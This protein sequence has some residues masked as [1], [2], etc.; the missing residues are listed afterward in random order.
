MFLLE[1]SHRLPGMSMD[2]RPIQPISLTPRRSSSAGPG[3]VRAIVTWGV[4]AVTRLAPV[5]PVRP[6]QRI[7]RSVVARARMP[8]VSRSCLGRQCHDGRH[9][10]SPT[11]IPETN[12][13]I[14]TPPHKHRSCH[15]TSRGASEFQT[16]HGHRWAS[17]L[18]SAAL[19]SPGCPTHLIFFVRSTSARHGAPAMRSRAR[20]RR[21][22]D[23]STTRRWRQGRRVGRLTVCRRW[24]CHR[25]DRSESTMS[26]RRW[27]SPVT[28]TPP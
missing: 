18:F 1:W 2:V 13:R 11:A 24:R 7:S 27:P 28:T 19:G 8:L 26:P 3:W 9:H 22:S 16:G 4:Q 20:R 5:A 17:E 10:T 12:P 6:N 23:R 25:T 21:R 14:S 15:L